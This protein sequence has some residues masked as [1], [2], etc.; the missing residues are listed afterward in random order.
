[1]ANLVPDAQ[2]TIYNAAMQDLHDT[3]KRSITVWR[4]SAEFITQTD[5]NY[6]AFSDAG[7]QN[8]V[9]TPESK[10]FQARIKYIDRQEKEFGIIVGNEKID[11]TQDFQL[12]RIKVDQETFEYMDDCEKVTIDGTDFI[13][14]TEPRPHGLLS[15]MFYTI[16][17]RSK[18]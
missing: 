9:Y 15:P 12:V 16:Y 6:D 1:M 8:I 17:L 13:P 5:S 4:S 2:R 7:I 10:T 18:P 3:F 14:I 11:L